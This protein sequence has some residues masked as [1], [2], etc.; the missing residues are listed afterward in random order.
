MLR[1]IHEEVH[2]YYWE[3]YMIH[4]PQVGNIYPLNL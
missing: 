2:Q 4:S 1:L 3:S